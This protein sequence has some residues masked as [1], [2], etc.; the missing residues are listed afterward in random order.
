MF[1]HWAASL[2]QMGRPS[3]W[4][5]ENSR[6]GHAIWQR[7]PARARARR[8]T[9]PLHSLNNNAFNISALSSKPVQP[10]PNTKRHS[11]RPQPSASF[12]PPSWIDACRGPQDGFNSKLQRTCTCCFRACLR[13][14]NSGAKRTDIC[15]RTG[16]FSTKVLR[17]CGMSSARSPCSHRC[18][19]IPGKPCPGWACWAR[20]RRRR[21]PCAWRPSASNR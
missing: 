7:S 21:T 14:G 2:A 20:R 6:R 15:V 1:L 3:S 11:K 10:E 9:T 4:N 18:P 8:S 19:P 13:Q 16:N 12:A 5:P 17:N